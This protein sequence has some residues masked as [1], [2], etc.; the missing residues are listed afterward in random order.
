[1]LAELRRRK[2]FQVGAAYVLVGW[3]VVQA[4]SIAFPVFAAPDWV[5]R[6]FIFVLLLGFPLALVM[7]WAL[8][9]TPEG[10]RVDHAPYGNKR[11]YSIALVLA[12]LAI[13]WFEFGQPSYRAGE[14]PSTDGKTSVAVLPFANMS[15][16][17]D[18]E[19]FS[20]GMTEEL[21][22]VL[23][24]NPELNVAARTSVFQFKGAAAD[25]REI[26][27]KL[28]VSHIVEGS[29]RR[30]D[31]RVRVT[32]Q[33]IRVSD[34]FHVWSENYD[35]RLESMFTLQDDIAQRIAEQLDASLGSGQV[36]AR[37]DDISPEAYDL[38]LRGRQ[39]YRQRGDLFE[40]LN[41]FIRTVELAPEFADG[42]ASLA[43]SYE[44]VLWDQQ[45][46]AR[47]AVGDNVSGLRKAASRAKELAP[48]AP[49]TLHALG[50]LARA[51][52]RYADAIDFY[53]QSMASDPTYPFV[54][55]DLSEVLLSMGKDEA[56]LAAARELIAIDPQAA[57]FWGRLYEYANIKDDAAVRAEA[58]AGA[59]NAGLSMMRAFF[60]EYYAHIMNGRYD[61]AL[62]S[63]EQVEAELPVEVMM[64][65]RLLEW[66]LHGTE[67]RPG[68]TLALLD[69]TTWY[70]AL[71]L[72]AGEEERYFDALQNDVSHGGGYSVFNALRYPLAIPLIN[73]PRARQMLIDNGY[74][75]YWREHG[76]PDECWP[77]GEDDFACGPPGSRQ[78]AR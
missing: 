13:V 65:R 40:M 43:L 29:I 14:G 20:D 10:V 39:V 11:L 73:T 9:V 18:E 70:A 38:Y 34:G 72:V 58:Q 33:L 61:E 52:G 5:L 64:E 69:Q 53:G 74:I 1:M 45:G 49:M 46:G 48:L 30:E 50:N 3:L 78:A 28:G 8:E 4:A 66:A 63:L 67:R 19:Y 24:R 54:R 56:G 6:V 51:E 60:S 71:L 17:P 57:V 55:E 35:R 47:Y 15:G 76:W 36:V 62:R 75:E 27:R 31:D 7:A 26:G 2:V 12:L 42:W 41:N 25:V 21:L 32:A 37:R 59:K 22:N 68:E 23:A 16:D 77:V 44:L